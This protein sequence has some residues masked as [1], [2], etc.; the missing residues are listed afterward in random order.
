[1]A[2]LPNSPNQERR[3]K[4]R[5]YSASTVSNYLYRKAILVF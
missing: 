5:N 1:L 3:N 2:I 4:L